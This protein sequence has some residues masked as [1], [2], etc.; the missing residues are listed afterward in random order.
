MKA[1]I[2]TT[3]IGTFALNED[4]K[5]IACRPF[6]DKIPFI[7]E[8]FE[9]SKKELI[10]EEKEIMEELKKQNYNEFTFPWAK[11]GYKAEKERYEWLKN[12][13]FQLAIELKIFKN[14]EEFNAFLTEIGI[15]FSRKR[16]REFV[17]K[18][19]LIVH[20]VGLLEDLNKTINLFVE[21]IR[22]W[23]SLHFPELVKTVE[24]HEKFIKL[25]LKYGHRKNF[26]E[27][28]E[29]AKKSFG[30]EFSEKDI[31]M[32]KI[33]TEEIKRLYDL[34]E[35]VESYLGQ[36]IA[37]IAPNLQALAGTILAAKLIAKAGSLEKLAKL[38]SSTIQLMGA[39]KALFRFLHKKGKSPK[40]GL[41]FIHPYIQKAPKKKRG[42]IARVLAA[43]LSMAAK[44]DCFSKKYEG[45][46]LK[47]ELEERIKEILEEKS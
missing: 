26:E 40:H 27:F 8:K 37:S 5:I 45:E 22:D 44:L 4:N 11:N 25:I 15:E 9:R 3:W 31:E 29:L 42:K 39:E 2:A 24:D 30:I 35:K 47:K 41:I 7:I 6:F 16:V 21:R 13:L 14:R 12:N 19:S 36:L 46:K 23:Y 18:D 20:V 43:K 33:F 1:F 28:E 17:G 32:V 34:R 10:E 38:P